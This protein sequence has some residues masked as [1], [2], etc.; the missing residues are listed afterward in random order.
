MKIQTY[1][2][3][4]LIDEV[5]VPDAPVVLTPEQERIAGLEA[6]LAAIKAALGVK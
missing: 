1:D 3:G 2:N 5:E 6:E 4:V